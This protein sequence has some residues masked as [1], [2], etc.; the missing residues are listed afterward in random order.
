MLGL[1]DID[2]GRTLGR[3]TEPDVVLRQEHVRDSP[4]DVRLVP[5]KPEQLR[6]GEARQRAVA[7]QLHEA[8]KP[9]PLLDLGALEL[10]PLVVPE[11]R[12]AQHAGL[13]VEDDKP[14]H[15]PR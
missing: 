2:V 1:R 9:D 15:L 13:L 10:G 11:D 3:Q 5:A 14:V 12:G 8:R 6:R 4:E 7:G